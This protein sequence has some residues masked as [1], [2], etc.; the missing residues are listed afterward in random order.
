MKSLRNLLFVSVIVF[1]LVLKLIAGE[2]R[3]L[4]VKQ[5]SY[6]PTIKVYVAPS[7]KRDYVGLTIDHNGDGE[8]TIEDANFA[9][10]IVKKSS[11]IATFTIPTM[12]Y[13]KEFIV[14]L[15]DEKVEN[16][17]CKWCN[18]KGYHLEGRLDRF[19]GTV[20]KNPLSF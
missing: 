20:K 16:C 17:G 3:I 13:G 14:A 6:P 15:W 19:Y 2:G 9:V 5:F 8:F 18:K 12:H 4:E 1:G 10:Q 7:D 11:N